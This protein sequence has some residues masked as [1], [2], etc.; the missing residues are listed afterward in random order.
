[1]PWQAPFTRPPQRTRRR[2][3][4]R[5]PCRAATG[6]PPAGPES[7]SPVHRG[8]W[9]LAWLL[10]AP[11]MAGFLI[12]A[13]YPLLRGVYLSFTTFHRA[14]PRAVDGARQLPRADPRRHLLELGARSRSTSSRCPS[15]SAS[16]SPC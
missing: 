7:S 12:F 8:D 3:P 5:R 1:M 9:R 6:G 10:I 16:S 15:A 11:A 2:P 13:V 14:H 4:R